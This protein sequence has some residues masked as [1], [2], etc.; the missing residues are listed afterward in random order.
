M[1]SR[2][3]GIT[4]SV[5]PKNLRMVARVWWSKL[6]RECA[7]PWWS[8][9][10][11]TFFW[12]LYSLHWLQLPSNFNCSSRSLIWFV[13]STP[14]WGSLWWF[15]RLLVS[16]SSVLIVWAFLHHPWCHT[17]SR[18]TL[19]DHRPGFLGR[20]LVHTRHHPTRGLWEVGATRFF[21][22]SADETNSMEG[23]NL[24]ARRCLQSEAA[25]QEFDEKLWR[26][27][28]GTVCRE[29]L[30][31]AAWCDKFCIVWVLRTRHPK[32]RSVLSLGK[33]DR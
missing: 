12:W 27:R 26:M 9:Y 32:E 25:E 28:F 5:L 31:T 6:K 17:E 15:C 7:A 8:P 13:L 20:S 19:W 2:P 4:D 21:P 30:R 29:S 14:H 10:E 3:N 1:W 16:M 18:A 24:I 23:M 33:C 11:W 22:S